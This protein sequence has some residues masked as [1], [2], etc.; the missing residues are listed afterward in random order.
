MNRSRQ[1]S[2]I[3][4]WPALAAAVFAFAMPVQAQAQS[5]SA[6]SGTGTTTPPG[7]MQRGVPG[8]DVDTRA[9]G[10]PTT[11]GVPGVDVDVQR[12]GT[13]RPERGR[14]EADTRTSGAGAAM[15]ADERRARADRN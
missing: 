11:G 13:A 14:P 5:S 15:T 12:R 4:L 1:T 3:L 9:G 10:Q 6:T 7:E 8:V 2:R